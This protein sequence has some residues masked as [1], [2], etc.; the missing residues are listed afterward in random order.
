MDRKT[1][2]EMVSGA[3]NLR[4]LLDALR[5]VQDALTE[6]DP[7]NRNLF[8]RV[9]ELIDVTDLPTYGGE[10]PD[11]TIGVWSWDATSLLVGEGSWAECRIVDRNEDGE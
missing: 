8:V 2:R 10:E 6:E 11:D 1:V 9:G 5:A 7:H 4:G 3:T